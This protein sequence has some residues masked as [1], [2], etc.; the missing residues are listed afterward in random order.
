MTRIIDALSALRPGSAFTMVP[1]DF[2]TLVW[3][4]PN[5]GPPT[6]EEV[7]AKRAELEAQARIDAVKAEARRR[8]LARFPEWH[9]ANMTA[10]GV[11][12]LNIRVAVGS[13]TAPQAQEAA[14][15]GVAWDW[16]KAVRAASDTIEALAPIP[17][18]FASD[19]RWP[20]S[21]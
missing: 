20:E 3:Q 4:D 2:A 10:R 15:L 18:D 1:G 9:Q 19:T 16:I 7:L 17:A 14:A 12:L 11:E 5:R 8:I 21:G 6:L 13:W